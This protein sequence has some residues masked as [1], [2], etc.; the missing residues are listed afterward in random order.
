MRV[1]IFDFDGTLY[2]SETFQLLM[3]HLKH[4]PIHK[5]RYKSF[6][7]SIL[8]PYIGY[9]MKLVP[10]SK[11]RER[12]MQIYLDSLKAL[13]KQ[14]L[15]DYFAELTDSVKRG[16]NKE[17]TQ[18]LQQHIQDNVQVMLV[19]GAYTPLLQAVTR[20]LHFDEIIGT[21]IEFTKDEHIDF[22]TPLFHVQGPRKTEKI[23]AA[24]HG[25]PI[26]WENSFAY[27]DSLSDLPVLDLVGNPV[28]VNPESRLK[29]IAEQRNWEII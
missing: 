22:S 26:D 9:K 3:N 1:A 17:I 23:K 8:P 13:S 11:M 2:S 21:D 14:E 5:S 16:F 19:S 6:F 15:E 7:R 25:K 24:L 18:R 20:D 10:E 12:S 4:H 27:G 28:A 29:T